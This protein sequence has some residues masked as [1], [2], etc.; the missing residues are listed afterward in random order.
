MSA[1]L[2]LLAEGRR[3]ARPLWRD[4]YLDLLG[5]GEDPTGRLPGQRLMASRVLPLI[6]ERLWRPLGGRVLMGALGPGMAGSG[7]SRWRCSA[8]GA[9]DAVLDVACGPGN[10]TRA[11]ADAAGE[12]GVAVG[13][14]ASRTMLAQA[15]RERRRGR[16]AYVRASAT[17]LPFRDG[18]F[19]AVCCFA[20]LYLIEEPLLAVAEI[21]RVLAPGGRVA[22]LSSVARGPLPARRLG[23]GRAAVDRRAD[24]RPR[25]AHARPARA[26]PD[27]RPRPRL[28]LRPVRLRAAAGFEP[29]RTVASGAM[30]VTFRR[31]GERRYAVVARARGAGRRSRWTRR[32]GSTRASRT[33]SPTTPSS[34]STA[35]SSASSASSPSAAT[36]RRSAASTA[37]RTAACAAAASGSAPPPRRARALRALSR[38]RRC[39]PGSAAAAPRR[40]PARGA[41]ARIELL[42]RALAHGRHRRHRHRPLARAHRQPRAP[43]GADAGPPLRRP[44][45]RPPHAPLTH[46]PP[47]PVTSSH[48]PP[49]SDPLEALSAPLRASR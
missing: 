22:L 1:L 26:R 2:E 49:G 13:L 15:A 31:T 19:D 41:C 48:P 45:P 33:T 30:E 17:D 43:P 47:A 14:D 9:G 18:S 46:A 25:G 8:I 23:R 10:F 20:A 16:R 44:A 11:F 5:A 4:G 3:P 12:D 21:A 37:R 34:S 36:S 32:P 39:A 24:L 29:R 35:S 6:Y 27:G 42:S 28:R 38:P 40:R 7:G